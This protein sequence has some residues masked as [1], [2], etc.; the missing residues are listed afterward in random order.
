MLGG[1]QLGDGEHGNLDD[2]GMFSS[3]VRMCMLYADKKQRFYC[4][5][6]EQL[7]RSEQ[8]HIHLPD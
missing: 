2:S 1:T 5:H 8:A 4:R 6:G 7:V 3:Q